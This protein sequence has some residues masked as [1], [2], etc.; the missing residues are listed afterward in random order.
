MYRDG[1]IRHLKPAAHID[2]LTN[3]ETALGHVLIFDGMKP[4]MVAIKS[5]VILVTSLR[6]EFSQASHLQRLE[7]R[8]Y[9]MQFSQVLS[10]L[11]LMMLVLLQEHRK[12]YANGLWLLFYSSVIFKFT[13]QPLFRAYVV[14]TA[15]YIIFSSASERFRRDLT[16]KRLE[17]HQ[18]SGVCAVALSEQEH[19][20]LL[21]QMYCGVSLRRVWFLIGSCIPKSSTLSL[22]VLAEMKVQCL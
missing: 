19:I 3:E 17:L 13:V 11:T 16:C 9:R 15:F 8:Q 22:P 5:P 21:M 2:E 1:I 14:I 7:S 20:F 10:K 4:Q 18:H 12:D 6:L